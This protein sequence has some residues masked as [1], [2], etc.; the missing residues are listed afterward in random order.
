MRCDQN[1]FA[2]FADRVRETPD[3]IAV[4]E[5][6]TKSVSYRELAVRAAQ[7]GDY[8]SAQGVAAEEPVGVLMSRT[9]EMVAVLL[10]IMKCGAAYVPVDPD[11]PP[12][13]QRIIM[14]R[15]GC[16]RVIAHRARIH[17]MRDVLSASD[18]QELGLQFIDIDHIPAATVDPL[19]AIAPGDRRL[20]YILYTSGST[21]EPK[22]VEIEHRSVVNLLLASRNLIAFT[23]RD[24]F[25]ACSTI[26]FDISVVELFLPL[27]TGGRLLMSD[28]GSL[29]EP[30]RLAA[31]I[32]ACGVTCMQTG[33]SMW[34]VLLGA[35]QDFPKLRVAISTAEAIPVALARSLVPC[36]EQVWNLYGPTETTIWSTGYRMTKETLDADQCSPISVSIGHPLAHT[37]LLILDEQ[38]KPVPDG[39]TGE[40]FIGGMGLA[41]GY[42]GNTALTAAR[43]VTIDGNRFYRTGDVVAWS[44]EGNLLYFGRNDDQMKIRGVRIDPAEV[45]AAIS[46]HPSVKQA[47]ATW[48]ASAG[49]TRSIVAAV[50]PRTEGSPVAAEGLHRWLRGRL[51]DP[52]VPSRYVF[53]EAL[54][55]SPSGKI[56][57]VTIRG[58]PSVDPPV[59]SCEVSSGATPTER[60]VQTVWQRTLHVERVTPTAHFFTIGG[61]SLAAVRVLV[62][63]EEVLGVA[64]PVQAVFRSPVLRDFAAEVDR[65]L[66][67]REGRRGIRVG[68]R[69]LFRSLLRMFTPTSETQV[70]AITE[71]I[72]DDYAPVTDARDIL[73]KQHTYVDPWQGHRLKKDA[74]VVSLN[75][76]GNRPGLFWCLQ[77]YRELTQLAGFLGREQPVHGMRSGYLIIRYEDPAH[78]ETLASCYADEITAIQPTGPLLLGG[79]CQGGFI[80]RAV[81]D[82]LAAR[83]RDIR[84][85]VLMEQSRFM[86]YG[87]PVALIFGRDSHLNP[88]LDPGTEKNADFRANFPA[89]YELVFIDG[90]HGQFFESPNIESLATI[91]KRLL[92][93]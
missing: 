1:I 71:P 11:D 49:G 2:L 8:V 45:E 46:A 31:E 19:S 90:A 44:K 52:M 17:G 22:G 38:L 30:A 24:C 81:A 64:L 9:A 91:L 72:A 58:M 84:L 88:Y 47:A 75:E 41:R 89:G 26:G 74:L 48:Y 42:R 13:R 53:C 62:Q 61:D 7:V 16:R 3:A 55:L 32:R 70:P 68:G 20:A 50:V 33:P 15:S 67:R 76:K 69:R 78:L 79:N 63:I 23:P 54:P 28:R 77:G 39:Q 80:M 5:S 82:K 4:I 40:L 6:K 35:V 12:S 10:G 21:G 43:F 56:D 34:S 18:E 27:I 86:P 60:I 51:P 29:L 65:A 66:A 93:R 73:P 36:G 87:G 92:A 37:S 85:L 83:G 14:E 59:A 25:L 57:R